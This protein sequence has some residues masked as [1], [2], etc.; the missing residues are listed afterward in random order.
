MHLLNVTNLPIYL[1]ND[2]APV[3]FGDPIEAT[4]TIASPGVVTAPGYDAPAAGDKVAFSTTGALPTGLTPGT[5]YYVVSPSGDTFEVA[6]TAGGSAINTSGSQSGVHTV[7]LLSQEVDGVKL[8]FKTGWTVLAQNL[9]G[10]TLVLQGANDLNAGVGPPQGPGSWSTLLNA[11]GA[12]A[13]SLATLSQ[14][15]VIL[16]YDWIRVSTSGTIQLIQE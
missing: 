15:L 3:P 16:G 13:G 14:A 6:A 10:G 4:M 1:P 9:T 7:H 11:A 5:V 2:V 12:A 8:P